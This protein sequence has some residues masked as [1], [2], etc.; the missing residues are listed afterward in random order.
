MCVNARRSLAVQRQVAGELEAD[1]GEHLAVAARDGVAG[2]LERVERRVQAEDQPAEPAFAVEQAAAKERAPQR[3]DRVQQ[4]GVT[5]ELAA[6]RA[7]Q[8]LAADRAAR[9]PRGP[10]RERAPVGA[11]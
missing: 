8:V 6:Q 3:V 4:L 9:L 1:L 10:G 7:E 5:A 11:R 2:Q